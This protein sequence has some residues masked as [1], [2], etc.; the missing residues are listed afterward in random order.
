MGGKTWVEM[1]ARDIKDGEFLM[2]SR[3]HKMMT[4]KPSFL[5]VDK[6][7][8]NLKADEIKKLNLTHMVT[9]LL[10]CIGCINVWKLIWIPSSSLCF[11]LFVMDVV[12][13]SLY[14]QK[15]WLWY[16]YYWYLGLLI[17]V[18]MYAVISGLILRMTFFKEMLTICVSVMV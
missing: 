8:E 14:V 1:F 6:L 5:A 4:M 10:L 13:R 7:K 18:E 15:W 2:K 17:R 9:L 3:F 11:H 16:Y 12:I